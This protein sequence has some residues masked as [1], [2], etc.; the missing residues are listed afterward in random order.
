MLWT[1]LYETAKGTN[2]L[3]N[4]GFDIAISG[5]NTNIGKKMLTSSRS[6]SFSYHVPKA[7]DD[8]SQPKPSLNLFFGVL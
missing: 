6:H 7:K 8:R 3:S 2:C 4:R 1:L 5:L